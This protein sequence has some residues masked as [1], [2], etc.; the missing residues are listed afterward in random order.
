MFDCYPAMSCQ[1][2]TTDTIQVAKVKETKNN[3]ST[4]PALCRLCGMIGRHHPFSL[5]V[6]MSVMLTEMTA[7]TI[8][9]SLQIPRPEPRLRR[10]SWCDLQGGCN[11]PRICRDDLPPQLPIPHE[12]RL[13]CSCNTTKAK[14]TDIGILHRLSHAFVW[15][16]AD[17]TL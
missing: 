8:R 9:A 14:T 4:I 15:Q 13:A 7:F 10:C 16:D 3:I 2:H 5:R 17:G 6:D 1:R 12:T 11:L